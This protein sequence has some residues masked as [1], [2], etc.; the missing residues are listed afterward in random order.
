MKGKICSITIYSKESKEIENIKEAIIL[1]DQI[2]GDEQGSIICIN[3]NEI[4]GTSINS[5]DL[6]ENMIIDGL[7]FS[8]LKDGIRMKFGEY[9]VLEVLQIIKEKYKDSQ[10]N[11]VFLKVI[12][13]GKIRTKDPIEIL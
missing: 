7:D 9:A 12:R 8:T 11:K 5:G 3:E 10:I 13:G 6:A 2:E 4:K 1:K